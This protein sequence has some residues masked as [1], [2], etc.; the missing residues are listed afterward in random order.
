MI[1][2]GIDVSKGKSTVCILKPGGEVLAPPFEIIHS[3]ESILVLVRRIQSYDE[4][5]R[6]ILEATGYYHLPVVTL[7]VEKGIFVCPVNALQIKNF[8]SQDLRKAKTDKI[9]AINIAKYGLSHWEELQP[10][11]PPETVYRELRL[12]ARQYYQTT[13]LITKE[14]VNISNLLD[15][16]MPGLNRLFSD[17]YNSKLTNIAARY[18]HFGRIL[19]MGEKRFSADFCKWAKKQ[20]YRQ[21]ERSANEIF[22]LAQN[23]IP[24]LPFT[25]STKISVTEAIRLLHQLEASRNTILA[26]MLE[27]AKTLPEFSVIREMHGV[28]DVLAVRFI[29]EIGDV[30]RFHSKR[31]VTAYAGID[32]PPYES[33]SFVAANRHI[34]KR[35]NKYLRKTGFEIMQSKLKQKPVNDDVYIY[36]KKKQSEGKS[37]KEANIAG[38]NKFLRIYYGKVN[39]LYDEIN[40]ELIFCSAI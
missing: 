39:A 37:W 12:L 22:A 8:R 32:T 4:E 31:A 26:Q 38:L 21:C 18:W 29:A 36:I 13:A 9:D 14:R 33:G 2:V 7:L 34:T 5:T 17:N 10:V 6:V 28:G 30:R 16:A 1:C 24:V 3:I 25:L 40:N 11:L 19:D 35:G 20:G 23:G 27:L 15:Q